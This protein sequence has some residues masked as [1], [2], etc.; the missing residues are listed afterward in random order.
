[1]TPHNFLS[2]ARVREMEDEA[3]KI[4]QIQTEVDKQMHLTSPTGAAAAAAPVAL[5]IEEKMEVDGR[6]VYVGNVS[7]NINAL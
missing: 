7:T 2:T 1:M 3:E 4:R 6:S 5:S